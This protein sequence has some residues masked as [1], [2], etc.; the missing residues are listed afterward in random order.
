[1]SDPHSNLDDQVNDLYQ[2]LGQL[3]DAR[4]VNVVIPA[5]SHLIVAAVMASGCTQAG[6][7][8]YIELLQEQ[9]HTAWQMRRAPRG[10]N[11]TESPQ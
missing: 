11:G 5:L 3:C 6:I 1:M 4:G 9:L 10:N 2:E 7:D 8:D